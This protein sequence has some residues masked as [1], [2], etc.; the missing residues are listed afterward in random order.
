MRP[1]A[2]LF[3]LILFLTAVAWSACHRD[4]ARATPPAAQVLMQ[5]RRHLGALDSAVAQLRRGVVARQPVA[6][7]RRAFQQVRLAYKRV[8]F[9]TEYYAPSMAKLLNGPALAEVE[10]YDQQQRQ[11]PAEGLQVLETYFYPAPYAPSRQAEVLHQLDLIRSTLI[12]LHS[13][14]ATFTPTDRHLFDAL[15]LAV[16]RVVT[17]GLP[18]FDTPASPGAVPEAAVVLQTVG[19]AL[20]PYQPALQQR[21]PRLAARLR[22]TLAASRAYLRRHPSATTIDQLAFL[23]EYANPLS[24]QLAQAQRVLGIGFFQEVRALRP[25]AATLFDSAAFNPMAFAPTTTDQPTAAQAALGRQLFFDP[26]LSGNNTRSCGSCHRSELAFTDR[27]VKSLSFDGRGQVARNAPTLLNA[28]LQSTQFYDGRVN[29]LEDQAAEVLANPLEMH[30]SLAAA[31]RAFS[32]QAA[33]RAAF[34]QAFPETRAGGIR[35]QHLKTALASYLRR[36]L[37]RLNAPFDR[38][39]RG[40]REALGPAARR[41]FNLFMGKGRCGTCHFMPLFNGTVPPTFE[42]TE[43]EVLGVPATAS[44]KPRSLDADPGRQRVH[45][46]EWQRHAFK[47][48]TLRNVAL[49]APYMHNGAYRTLAEVV[50]FYAAGGGAGLGLEVPN[51]TLPVDRIHLNAAEKRDLLAFLQALTDTA[52]RARPRPAV[53]ARR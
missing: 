38:Y 33:Y 15:R 1:K 52:G 47:T 39:V 11:V 5:Y 34:A 10:A 2:L 3:A 37:V 40:E 43:S 31:A 44:L 23:T 14:A 46:I 32:R 53:L 41:G 16:F 9:L 36:D 28:A 49:T 35:E 7:Q 20:A 6:A 22:R 29:Y 51:Q 26:G 17:L 48:P 25:D 12:G 19:E 24:R 13:A 45:G 50:D 8:E 42:R 18:A 30:G 27:Q 4:Q 21:Q